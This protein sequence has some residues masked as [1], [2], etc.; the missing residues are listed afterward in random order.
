MPTGLGEIPVVFY[1]RVSTEHEEQENAFEQQIMWYEDLLMRYP[2]WK[3]IRL[4][5]DKGITGT[6][7][8][9]R[10][11]FMQMMKDAGKGEFRLI[12]TR[13]VCRF[14]RNTVDTLQYP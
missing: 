14:A 3:K 2:Q 1:A 5:T 10:P 12:V 4:Y 9:C 11:G 13:E 8:H 6:E 7:A